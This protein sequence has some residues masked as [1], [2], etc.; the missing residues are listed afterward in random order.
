M[1]EALNVARNAAQTGRNDEVAH[2]LDSATLA[3]RKA[4]TVHGRLNDGRMSQPLVL[5][6]PA[7]E[8]DSDSESSVGPDSDVSSMHSR[9]HSMDTAPTI[10]TKSAQS[11]QQPILVDQRK[12]IGQFPGKL[13]ASV[14]S[15]DDKH[16]QK[17]SPDRHSMSRT[18]PRLYQ[19][20]SADSIVRDFAYARAKTAKAEAARKFSRSYGSAADYYGDT[21]QSVGAQPGVRPSVSA[22]VVTDKPLPKP[23]GAIQRPSIGRIN[24][25]ELPNERRQKKPV[26]RVEPTPTQT[27]PPRISSR[28]WPSPPD[29]E[30]PARHRR[31][32]HHRPHLS[33]LFESPQ[34][35]QHPKAQD[36]E[37]PDPYD[38]QRGGSLV[39]DTR[40]GPNIPQ[41]DSISKSI[42]RDSGPTTLL[43]RNISLRHP[44]RKHISLNEGQGFSLGRYHRRQPIAREW[45]TSR[46]R[47][48]ATIACLNT[49]LVGLIAGIYVSYVFCL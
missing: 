3:L 35:H 38:K 31:P 17:V 16:E 28:S 43:Q 41:N 30:T 1:E 9:G 22:P 21:G 15:F 11:S 13:K 25:I 32:K 5:S 6:P 18:P 19:P 7:S 26:R 4:S 20:P 24:D 40:Y 33:D 44:R 10:L 48:T 42:T 45:S 46:K 39:T 47:I 14:E 34:Y 36:R 12:S 49:V 37:A 2:I 23:P 8:R 27:I 29:T